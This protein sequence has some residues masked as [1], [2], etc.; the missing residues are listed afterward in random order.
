MTGGSTKHMTK[1]SSPEEN[2]KQFFE[3]YGRQIR[4]TGGST[5]RFL[6]ALQG[7]NARGERV[8][9][10]KVYNSDRPKEWHELIGNGIAEMRRTIPAYLSQKDETHQ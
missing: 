10:W 5:S 9:G 2:V 1:A 4:G 6:D 7:L 3:N 8:K